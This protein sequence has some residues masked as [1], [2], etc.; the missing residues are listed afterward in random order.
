MCYRLVALIGAVLLIAGVSPVQAQQSPLSSRATAASAVAFNTAIN[1]VSVEHPLEVPVHEQFSAVIE[2]DYVVNHWSAAL[3]NSEATGAAP[4]CSDHPNLDVTVPGTTIR[5]GVPLDLEAAAQAQVGPAAVVT[6]LGRHLNDWRA[7]LD[8]ELHDLDLE[9]AV[10]S[11]FGP[12]WSLVAVGSHRCDWRAMDLSNV[13][14]SVMPLVAV[15]SDQFGDV[16]A[17]AVGVARFHSV[18][19]LVQEWY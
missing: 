19:G 15:A 1:R 8:G 7:Y 18:L 13:P 17:T 11:Q 9:A 4:T 14:P 3:V 2:D 16:D 12:S 6:S 10:E 5:P